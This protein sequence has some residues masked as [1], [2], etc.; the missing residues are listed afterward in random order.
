MGSGVSGDLASSG[1]ISENVFHIVGVFLSGGESGVPEGL[2]DILFLL[3]VESSSWILVVLGE[4]GEDL[5]EGGVGLGAGFVN[6]GLELAVS[7]EG[8][9]TWEAS[10]GRSDESGEGGEFHFLMEID[11]IYYI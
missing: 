7:V 9:E 6:G 4:I 5:L 2:V 1:V 11:N 10:G 3:G 8:V